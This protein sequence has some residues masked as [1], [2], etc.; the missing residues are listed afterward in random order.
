[1][2]ELQWLKEK[3]LT[4]EKLDKVRALNKLALDMG[5]SLPK[6]AIAWCLNNKDVSTVIL[7]ASK[8]HHLE[9]TLQSFELEDQFTPELTEQIE[10]ILGNKPKH[11]PY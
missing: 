8:P 10:G 4:E 3:T 7:G 2:K 1:M 6:L 11:P 5:T 9:E